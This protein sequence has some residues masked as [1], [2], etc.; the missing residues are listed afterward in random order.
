[1]T[2]ISAA[3]N[4]TGKPVRIVHGEYQG[5][6]QVLATPDGKTVYVLDSTAK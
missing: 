1:M 4:R 2:P 6:E 3:T 5:T